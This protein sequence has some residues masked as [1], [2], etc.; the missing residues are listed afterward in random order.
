MDEQSTP[1]RRHPLERIR[2][3][4]VR[5]AEVPE[6]T[7]SGRLESASERA[8]NFQPPRQAS[9]APAPSR[10]LRET[11]DAVRTSSPQELREGALD[12]YRREPLAFLAAAFL[13][14]FGVGKLLFRDGREKE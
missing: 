1:G 12:T 10:P 7:A 14:G 13:V 6:A 9:Y 3:W 8:A 5:G 4:F 11:W 2:R